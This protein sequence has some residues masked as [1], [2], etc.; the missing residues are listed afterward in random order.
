MSESEEPGI[1]LDDAITGV[2][3]GAL[4]AFVARRDALVKELRAAG[5][6]DDAASVKNLRKPSRVAWALDLGV[7]G[8]PH[9]M[10]AVDA[11]LGEIL[12][13]HA[14]QGDVRVAMTSL[15]NAVRELA[16]H[17]ARATEREGLPVDA[18][19]LSNALQTVLG[20]QDSLAQLRRGCLAEVPENDGLDFLATLPPPVLA[21]QIKPSATPALS[22]PMDRAQ[23]SARARHAEAVAEARKQAQ[24]AQKAV[25]EA[26]AGLEAAEKM[27]R[28]AEAKAQ[29]MRSDLE[30]ATRR[31]ETA[32][33]KLRKAEDTANP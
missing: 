2:Y 24:A 4:D 32:T 13:A 20:S 14:G 25:R 8:T 15:R 22:K 6:K 12:A 3:A 33:E 9:A 31:A 23:E 21:P 1:D 5:R 11:A 19:T 26:E 10:A 30:H 29:A 27:V 18:G 7:L 28:A 17:A 16:A